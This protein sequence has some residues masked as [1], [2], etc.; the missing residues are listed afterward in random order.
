VD[1]LLG[2][3]LGEPGEEP[4][5]SSDPLQRLEPAPSTTRGRRCAIWDRENSRLD[6]SAVTGGPLARKVCQRTV[7]GRY[8]FCQKLSVEGLEARDA[9]IT[10]SRLRFRGRQSLRLRENGIGCQ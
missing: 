5:V 1:W 2:V 10:T 3:I 8:I 7:A 9:Y 6:L 4:Q